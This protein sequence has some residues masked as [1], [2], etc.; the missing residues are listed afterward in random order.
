[1]GKAAAHCGN[2]ADRVFACHKVGDKIVPNDLVDLAK[3]ISRKNAEDTMC[4][5]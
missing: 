5:P 4:F 2:T 1:M 3:K